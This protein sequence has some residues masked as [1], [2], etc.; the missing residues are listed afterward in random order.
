MPARPKMNE[1]ELVE[2]FFEHILVCFMRIRHL[3]NSFW[4]TC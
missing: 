1:I 3:Q 4:A 2:L